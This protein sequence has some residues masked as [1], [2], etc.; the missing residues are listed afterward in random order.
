MT[1]ENIDNVLEQL[2]LA[3]GSKIDWQE[4][5]SRAVKDG[6]WSIDDHA[7]HKLFDGHLYP[8]VI[9]RMQCLNVSIDV[10]SPADPFL[11]AQLLVMFDPV[12]RRIEAMEV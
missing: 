3:G 5:E 8:A 4:G 6:Q 1:I 2:V 7:D 9:T 10:E 11:Q 12:T